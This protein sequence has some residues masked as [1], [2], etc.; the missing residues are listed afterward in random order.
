MQLFLVDGIITVPLAIIGFIFFP[1]LPSSF[2][3]AF[4]FRH[5]L[6]SFP[7]PF[8]LT[9]FLSSY[10]HIR[11]KPWHFTQEEHDLATTRLGPHHKPAGKLNFDVVK[12][13][14]KRPLYWVCVSMYVFVSTNSFVL[15]FGSNEGFESKERGSSKVRRSVASSGH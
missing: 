9:L 12:R 7:R 6:F 10:P 2:V 15:G 13:T 1:G 14:V 11:K 8:L 4:A 5:S 3:F